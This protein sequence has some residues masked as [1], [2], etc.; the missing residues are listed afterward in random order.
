[1]DSVQVYFT[2]DAPVNAAQFLVSVEFSNKGT[3]ITAQIGLLPG[4]SAT[5]PKSHMAEFNTGSARDFRV[6]VA[7]LAKDSHITIQKFV[8]AE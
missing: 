7:D 3:L 6:F 8:P 5:A 4:A 2:S 1:M